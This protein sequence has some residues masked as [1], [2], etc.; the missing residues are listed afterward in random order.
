MENIFY[1]PQIFSFSHFRHP[2]ISFSATNH[3]FSPFIFFLRKLAESLLHLVACFTL[4]LDHIFAAVYLTK[5]EKK[6]MLKK[7]VDAFAGNVC[8]MLAAKG[9]ITLHEIEKLSNNRSYFLIALGW[10]LR[11]D[12]I[13]AY[14]ENGDWCFEM[15]EVCNNIYY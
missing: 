4:I 5:L 8:N 1:S 9:K 14:Q 3:I 13:K 6:D 11:E 12:K 2:I 15:K 7:E 10:L